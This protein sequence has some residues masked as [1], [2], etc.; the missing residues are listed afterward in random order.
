MKWEQ[1]R[2]ECSVSSI[3]F[4]WSTHKA[5]WKV[6]MVGGFCKKQCICKVKQE[7]KIECIPGYFC[8]SHWTS[9]NCERCGCPAVYMQFGFSDLV[10]ASYS[11]RILQS[12]E[13]T[14]PVTDMQSFLDQSQRFQEKKL[15]VCCSSGAAA[16]TSPKIKLIWERNS[17]LAHEW[18]IF[19]RPTRLFLLSCDCCLQHT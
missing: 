17:S 4:L 3:I 15:C 9:I 14:N 6:W 11:F 1:W 8:A 18:E 7:Q 5:V 2:K 12:D 10:A 19:T 13:I 16:S